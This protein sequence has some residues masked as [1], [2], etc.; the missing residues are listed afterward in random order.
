MVEHEMFDL[1]ILV[2]S[3][4][5]LSLLFGG[6]VLMASIPVLWYWRRIWLRRRGP[7]TIQNWIEDNF[8][9][10]DRPLAT[11]VFQ[12]VGRA[13]GVEMAFLRPTDRFERELSISR[14][15]IYASWCRYLEMDWQ[16]VEEEINEYL[17]RA[18]KN[19]SSVVVLEGSIEDVIQRHSRRRD[20]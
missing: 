3:V 2:V 17:K 9:D 20:G 11:F 18:A 14:F 4:I 5:A 12:S 8:Q 16:V 7:V 13:M 1:P 10:S 6:L 19:D 15:A